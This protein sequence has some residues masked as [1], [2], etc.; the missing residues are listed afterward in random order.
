[1]NLL[2][3]KKIFNITLIFSFVLGFFVMTA[4]VLAQSTGGGGNVTVAA[5]EEDKGFF[6]EAISSA[7]D[8]FY[9]N[10][11][12]VVYVVVSAITKVIGWTLVRVALLLTVF[13]QY[14]D[15]ANAQPV[16]LGWT[17]LRDVAN[18]GFLIITLVI[19]I[20]TILRIQSYNLRALLPKLLMMAVL[21]NFS[22]LIAGLLIDGSQ[23]VMLTFLRAFAAA[24]DLG[25][26]ILAMLQVN[27]F[28]N[29]TL[30]QG[31][32]SSVGAT[33]DLVFAAISSLILAVIFSFVALAIIFLFAT[34]LLVRIVMLWFLTIVSPLAFAAAALPQTQGIS[35][36]WWSEF[37]RYLLIGPCV[38]FVLWL[39]F[40]SLNPLQVVD[41]P[42]GP[43]AGGDPTFEAITANLDQLGGGEQPISG[44]RSN[45]VWFNFF[46]GFGLLIGGFL[47]CLKFSNVAGSSIMANKLKGGLTGSLSWMGRRLD[48]RVFSPAAR[49]VGVLT[50]KSIKGVGGL[51]PQEGR[52]KGKLGRRLVGLGSDIEKFA[53]KMKLRTIPQSLALRRQRVEEEAIRGSAEA[54][55]DLFNRQIG[56]STGKVRAFGAF[57]G[58]IGSRTQSRLY[59]QAINAAVS[60]EQ[61]ELTDV[62]PQSPE[63]IKEVLNN[64]SSDGQFLG[65]N[66]S[67]N[68]AAAA[69]QV[70]AAD[71]NLNDFMHEYMKLHKGKINKFAADK[72]DGLQLDEGTTYSGHE[73]ASINKEAYDK[74][75]DYER[76][77]YVEVNDGEYHKKAGFS[78]TAYNNL[79]EKD[80]QKYDL[81]QEKVGTYSNKNVLLALDYMTGGNQEKTARLVNQVTKHAMAA[82]ESQLFGLVEVDKNGN[83]AMVDPR[84]M[85]KIAAGAN[86]S[87]SL[88]EPQQVAREVRAEMYLQQTESS[89]GEA[90]GYAGLQEWTF[91]NENILARL[92]D[93]LR[94]QADRVRPKARED[95]V[96][97][98]DR[99]RNQ[100]NA[101]DDISTNTKM[102]VLAG[103]DALEKGGK[104]DF[105]ENDFDIEDIKDDKGKVIRQEVRRKASDDNDTSKG[106][107][108]K[109][110]DTASD[111]QK[112]EPVKL[113]ASDDLKKVASELK[114]SASKS[115]IDAAL[116]AGDGSSASQKI[117]AEA[118]KI[119]LTSEI[120]QR[121][122]VAVKGVREAIIAGS[123]EQ[124]KAEVEQLNSELEKMQAILNSRKGKN[125]DKEQIVKLRVRLAANE[126]SSG[127]YDPKAL[128]NTLDAIQ[129]E[130]KKHKV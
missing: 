68:S 73:K 101:R 80:K 27:H 99:I 85:G 124:I 23:I 74:L 55:A 107:T 129:S 120:S 3:M 90:R 42:V 65:D 103:L 127:N 26:A 33:A 123:Q 82:G 10:V 2:R 18:L 105:K 84:E 102:R 78:E 54:G 125:A 58:D 95:F 121:S 31:T 39:S 56:F 98:A 32:I 89:N 7:F 45:T 111:A 12:Y 43:A 48:D 87:L 30:S 122:T 20:A 94:A 6:E 57:G 97:E 25:S 92:F 41:D 67:E 128:S 21:V 106:E 116:G 66:A 52:F 8:S 104:A 62:I 36:Q 77:K 1:M 81:T 38:A 24:G 86:F 112:S 60:G 50:G 22:R 91:K 118:T 69:L 46:I 100:V 72:F 83:R 130:V 126:N 63:Q 17:L 59:D 114:A 5:E 119:N 53:P 15:I 13:A 64:L 76:E 47:M 16:Q 29:D 117:S 70:A 11:A 93:S 75:S 28:Y 96:A 37:V 44:L 61:R 88:K 49:G 40:A 19:A 35:K 79:S 109:G 113:E 110:S 115:D 71:R 108:K 51:L 14:S 34:V 4:P 9:N